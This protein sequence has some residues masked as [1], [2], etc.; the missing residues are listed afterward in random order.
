MRIA[1]KAKNDAKEEPGRLSVQ[2]EPG[3]L[4]VVFD[5]AALMTIQY[6]AS[7]GAAQVD[8]FRERD[9][10]ESVHIVTPAYSDAS[11]SIDP[12]YGALRA[13]GELSIYDTEV[14]TE[15][16]FTQTS[17]AG[18]GV[19]TKGASTPHKQ[20][21]PAAPAAKRAATPPPDRAERQAPATQIPPAEPKAPVQA[22]ARSEPQKSPAQ[23]ID[24][25]TRFNFLDEDK[26]GSD[27]LGIASR[28]DIATV[29]ATLDELH[30]TDRDDVALG[31][32]SHASD[33]QLNALAQTEEGRKLL[34]RLYDEMTSGYLGDDE[35]EQAERLMT[36]RAQRIDVNKFVEAKDKAM[37]IPF[38]SIGFTK[39][40]SASLS[41]ERLDNGK[42]WVKSHMKTEHWK[43]AKRLPSMLFAA[44]VEGVELDPDQV[45]GLYLYDE[46]GKVIYVPAMHLLELG[47]Q[48]TTK[49]YTMAGEAVFTGLTMGFGGE[50]SAGAKAAR[51]AWALRGAKALQFADR[52]SAVV[53]V[54]GTLINDHRGLILEHFGADGERFLEIWGTVET[55]VGIYGLAR[56]VAALGKSAFAL[57]KAIKDM[58]VRRAQL[59]GLSASDEAALDSTINQAEKAVEDIEN[60]QQSAAQ[61]AG[62]ASPQ[63]GTPPTAQLDPTDAANFVKDH[64]PEKIAG[65]PGHRRASVGGGHEVVEVPD[66]TVPS[67]VGCEFHS[68]PPFAK[69]PC[70]PGM[71]SGKGRKGK[72]TEGGFFADLKAAGEEPTKEDLRRAGIVEDIRSTQRQFDPA[73]QQAE[74]NA[75][76]STSAKQ[77]GV[78]VAEAHHIG[79][80]Y[81][82][83]GAE[84]KRMFERLG[85]TVDSDMNL[86]KEFKEHGQM[87]GWMKWNPEKQEFIYMRNG[88]HPEYHAWVTERLRAAIEGLSAS[89]AEKAI[90]RAEA[91]LRRIITKNP[92]VLVYGL[93]ALPANLR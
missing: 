66:P 52:A 31:F 42:I 91:S 51:G 45:V 37:V 15:D 32:A 50:V 64:P 63:P 55:V 2:Q 92:D 22:D 77:A 9:G 82:P 89:E 7:S 44:G 53:G 28:G 24:S 27:L 34:L 38:S 74:M 93:Q 47:N 60:A 16:G 14:Q 35:K 84:N 87:R 49:A 43:D 11:R 20:A 58:R 59:R 29:D 6:K 46:G 68:P 69:V 10:G 40:S 61:G 48:E 70:P 72:K 79:T 67:G 57:R 85:F 83:L 36:A 23:L 80:K 26:L 90:K 30:S 17:G 41:V 86:I 19:T 73:S 8:I 54:A 5:G 3:R 78:D 13:A 25:S 62:E 21:A 71:G 39:F 65:E 56:G 18:F 4:V 88:H 76:S 1:L 33:G 75:F 81:G 12:R